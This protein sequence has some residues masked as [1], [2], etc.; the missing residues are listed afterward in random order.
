M[1]ILSEKLFA[2]ENQH[3][4]KEA[5]YEILSVVQINIYREVIVIEKFYIVYIFNL[6]YYLTNKM[7]IHLGYILPT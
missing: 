4:F 6:K 1:E 7:T 2:I 5:G 3:I